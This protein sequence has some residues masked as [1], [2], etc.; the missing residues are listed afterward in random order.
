M[1]AIIRAALA[2]RRT[3]VIE[4]EAME[5]MEAMVANGDHAALRTAI[6]RAADPS[7]PQAERLHHERVLV[8]A[9]RRRRELH[10]ADRRA[11]GV[12]IEK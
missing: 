12:I 5:A 8:T 6:D 2:A 10:F 3:A 4:A 11:R 7:L 9:L 1:F